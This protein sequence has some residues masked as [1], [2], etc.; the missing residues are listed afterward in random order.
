[1]FEEVRGPRTG[2]PEDA[3]LTKRHAVR[4]VAAVRTDHGGNP[5][6]DPLNDTAIV[7]IRWHADDALPF[8]LCLSA[9]TDKEHGSLFID[10]VTVAR[11]NIVLADHGRTVTGDVLG[12]VP[13]PHLFVAEPDLGHC[14]PSQRTP[15]PPR[16]RPRLRERPLT[17]AVPY[18]PAA[19]PDSAFATLHWSL[20]AVR[21]SRMK[22]QGSIAGT[23]NDWFPVPDLL[24]SGPADRNFVAESEADGT[25]FLRFGD[26]RH[27][28]R[29]QSD[30][31]FVAGYRV[32]NGVAGNVG[33]DALIHVVTDE[34]RIVGVRNPL[35]ARGG[36]D[37]E[38]IEDVRQRAPFAFRTQQRAV[39]EADYAEKTAL[40]PD[41]QRAAGMFRWTGS[42]HTVFV[43]VDRDDARPI[44]DQFEQEVRGH[45]EPFRMAGYDLEVDGPRFVPI[46]LDLFVCVK[47]DYF[48]ADVKA[49]LVASLGSRVLP[50]GRRG[51]FHPDN[52]TFQQPVYLSAIYAAAQSVTGVASVEVTRFQR[53]GEPSD[54]ALT[55]GRMDMGRLEIA[56]LDSDRNFPEHGVLRLELAG[57]K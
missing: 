55:L 2:R 40:H 54:E 52:F 24:A 47:P 26:G 10:D 15:V 42:W 20:G 33:A 49:A 29:P 14:T 3:D 5:L 27:G 39:T 6:V 41:V 50:D 7:E 28:T 9:H 34:A 31:S 32:G 51:L 1:V 36:I 48:R 37:P 4:L 23:T 17:Q 18:D 45:L 57:G 30:T 12:R 13:Q 22:L 43:T 56:R 44:T 46:E 21:P 11:G 16:F 19:P 25:V 38:Q 53:Q 35:P 8:P